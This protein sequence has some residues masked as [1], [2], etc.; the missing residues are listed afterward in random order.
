MKLIKLLL[1][2]SFFLSLSY[3]IAQSDDNFLALDLQFG[4]GP[5]DTDNNGIETTA[6]AIDY[7]V[8]NISLAE[9]LNQSNLCTRWD[10]YSIDNDA[11]STVCY[12]SEQCCNFMSYVP[13]RS[14]WSEPFVLTYNMYGSTNNN[15]V[16][17]Q[18]AYIN[19]NISEQNPFSEIYYSNWDSLPAVF[20][21]E[22]SS[23]TSSQ[24]FAFENQ[25]FSLTINNPDNSSSLITGEDVPLN[26]ETNTSVALRYRINNGVTQNLGTATS[27]TDLLKG[28]LF[29]DIL[30]N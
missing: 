22:S 5:Y 12:G 16:S 6:G 18:V 17:A 10:I 14:N 9:N 8:A 26:L 25:S 13:T 11:T 15:L 3:A 21:E 7:T 1:F 19:Y 23:F 24:I 4:N 29:Y 20:N 2:V 30:E 27:F 28:T